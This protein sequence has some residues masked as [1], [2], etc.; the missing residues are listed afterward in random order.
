MP[1]SILGWNVD[2]RATK[3][4]VLFGLSVH[5]AELLIIAEEL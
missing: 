4:S 5:I 1:A 3:R 2:I